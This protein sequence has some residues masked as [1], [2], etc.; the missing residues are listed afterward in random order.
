MKRKLCWSVTIFMFCLLY[1]IPSK[2]E[3][4]SYRPFKQVY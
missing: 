3:A 2:V 1:F 4:I